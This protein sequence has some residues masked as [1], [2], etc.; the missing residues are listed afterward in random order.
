MALSMIHSTPPPTVRATPFPRADRALLSPR[1]K[2]LARVYLQ[3]RELDRRER[4]LD[5]VRAVIRRRLNVDTLFDGETR[6]G[7]GR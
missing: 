2:R 6:A 4:D 3:L 1:A 5:R 7:G